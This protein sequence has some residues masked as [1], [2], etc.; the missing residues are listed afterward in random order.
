MTRFDC[1][2]YRRSCGRIFFLDRWLTT[3]DVAGVDKASEADVAIHMTNHKVLKTNSK[4][5]NYKWSK[6][7]EEK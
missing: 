5:E 2:P 1:R 6:Q 3:G 7:K 4:I